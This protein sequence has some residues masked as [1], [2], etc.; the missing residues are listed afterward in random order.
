MSVPG[1]WG[2]RVFREERQSGKD[3]RDADRVRGDR[4]RIEGGERY[5]GSGS[6]SN[7]GREWREEVVRVFGEKGGAEE[8]KGIEEDVTEEAAGAHGAGAIRVCRGDA[9]YAER[10]DRSSKFEREGDMGER[11]RRERRSKESSGR[12]SGRDMGGGSRSGG[13]RYKG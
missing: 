8:P 1:R 4:E 12:D 7:G 3:T 11:G 13:S 10:E 2:D 5:R 9:A 6:R